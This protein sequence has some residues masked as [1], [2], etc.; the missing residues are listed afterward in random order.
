MEYKGKNKQI[1]CYDLLPK[2]GDRIAGY[3]GHKSFINKI[4]VYGDI[5]YSASFDSFIA[6]WNSKV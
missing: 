2:N 1:E 6:M 3:K 4:L 5:V